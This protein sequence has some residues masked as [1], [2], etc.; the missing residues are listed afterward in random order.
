M[1]HSPVD[2]L[3]QT[4]A[5][6][7]SDQWAERRPAPVYLTVPRKP[8]R[9]PW[10]TA[11]LTLL[12]LLACLAFFSGVYFLAPLRTNVL[13]LGIDRA[14]DGTDLSR[15]DTNILVTIVPLQPYV[16]MLSIPR[17]LW[18]NVPGVGENRI[19]TAHFFAENN[20][21]GSGPY[22]TMDTIRQNFGVDANYYVRI[23]FG[24]LQEVVDAIGGVELVLDSPTAGYP[25][26]VHRLNGEQALAFVRDRSG[27][28]DFFRMQHG[29]LFLTQ[30]V[31]QMVSPASWPRFPGVL[32]ALTAAVD[33]NIPLWQWPRLGLAVLRARSSG[34]DN[35]IISRDMVTPFTTSAGAQV[36]R[37]EWDRINPVLMEM[38]GQ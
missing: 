5:Q 24:G 21:P 36:L 14:P 38:F 13:L 16:G 34:M 26:G 12:L 18:V 30:M 4:R 29:Q 31:E 9:R 11:C 15:T 8:S 23:R 7:V 28:D 33:T 10:Q 22:A 19:N 25:P 3:A 20:E 6:R 17:D 37:P 1:S 32:R 27:T 2:P 35:R